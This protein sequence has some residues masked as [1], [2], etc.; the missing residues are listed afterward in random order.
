MQKLSVVVCVLL[1][2]FASTADAKPRHRHHPNVQIGGYDRSPAYSGRPADCRGIPWC[3]CWLRHQFGFADKALNLARNWLRFSPAT[4]E[5]GNIVV[6][7]G[8]GHVGKVIGRN[9]NTITVI[10]GN[11]GHG[12]VRIRELK[13]TRGFHFRRV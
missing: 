10:S 7:P 9:G 13:S 2:L 5:T 1:S 11:A 3:G 4:A 12:Q 8:G 6:W